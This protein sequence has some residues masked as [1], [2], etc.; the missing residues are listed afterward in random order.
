[1]HL[2][3]GPGFCVTPMLLMLSFA[4]VKVAKA[5]SAGGGSVLI[6]STDCIINADAP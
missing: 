2:S 6:A 3:Y 4:A 1:M 5:F